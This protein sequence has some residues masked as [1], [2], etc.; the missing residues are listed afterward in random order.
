MAR[1][2]MLNQYERHSGIARQRVKKL[3]V[4]FQATRRSTDGYHGERIACRISILAR[5][6]FLQRGRGFGYP[7][8]HLRVA[9]LFP[10][11]VP[12]AREGSKLQGRESRVDLEVSS[13]TRPGT[14][15]MVGRPRGSL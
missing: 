1:I 6:G 14:I 4:C 15:I 8:F 7:G 3:F 10:L 2:K 9:P 13:K 11:G 5:K 12:G